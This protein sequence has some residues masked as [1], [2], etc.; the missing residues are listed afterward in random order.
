M[1]HLSTRAAGREWQ[2]YVLCVAMFLTLILK[3]LLFAHSMFRAARLGIRMKSIL[4]AAI[5]RKV[6]E[7]TTETE[8]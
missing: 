8:R 1:K 2:G 5:Y 7:T 4:I 6:R 3:S